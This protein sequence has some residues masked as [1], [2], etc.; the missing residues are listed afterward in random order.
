LFET[1]RRLR[2]ESG[3]AQNQIVDL[4]WMGRLRLAQGRVDEAL[5]FTTRAVDQLASLG[6][7]LF[8]W[9]LPVIFSLHAETLAAADDSLESWRYAKLAY[10]SLMRFA[11]QMADPAVREIFLSIPFNARIIAAGTAAEPV[12]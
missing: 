12:R 8:V 4:A 10:D 11:G 5:S 3:E 2:L 7:D 9:E 1:T 6:D